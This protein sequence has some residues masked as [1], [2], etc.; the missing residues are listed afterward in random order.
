M[1]LMEVSG[2]MV[3]KV[4]GTAAMFPEGYSYSYRTI[5]R[6]TI[7]L[8][9]H[10]IN[11]SP[12]I[13][14]MEMAAFLAAEE[15][16]ARLCRELDAVWKKLL[17][18]RRATIKQ[19]DDEGAVVEQASFEERRVRV[20]GLEAHHRNMKMELFRAK[21]KRWECS[22]ALDAERAKLRI[23]II[24]DAQIVLATLSGSASGHLSDA[25]VSTSFG[26][27]T[28]IVD[29]AGQAVE[30]STLIPLRYGCSNLILVGDPRQLPATI[31]S[32]SVA[33]LG[34]DLSLFE[35]LERG[36][37]RVIMLTVQYRMHPKIRAFPSSQFYQGKL[38]DAKFLTNGYR[39]IS[40]S[41]SSSTTTAITTTE[42]H[43]HPP[44]KMP[45]HSTPYFQVR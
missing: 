22:R 43:Q 26:F 41:S 5:P 8:S 29:E 16:V 19:Q 18:A 15:E 6:L 39:G 3:M 33:K 7:H 23:A 34:Y 11:V 28:V 36:G 21:K 35:R 12:H 37:H 9:F 27:G 42:S 14:S 45:Y 10:L 32:P 17:E 20:S 1:I 4:V 13:N 31:I 44:V 30:P 24:R 38:A 25:V 40:S 2:S